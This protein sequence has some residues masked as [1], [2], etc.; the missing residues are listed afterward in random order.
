MRFKTA[1]IAVAAVA[2]SFAAAGSA[3]AQSFA[4]LAKHSSAPQQVSG[5]RLQKGLLPGSAFGS[6]FT[7]NNRLNTGSRLRS[8]HAVLHVSSMKCGAFEGFDYVAGFGN[9]AGALDQYNNPSWSPANPNAVVYGFQDVMQFASTKAATNFYNASLSKYAACHSF[10][11][12]NPGDKSPGGGTLQV[13]NLTLSKIKVNGDHAFFDTQSVALSEFPGS[14]LYLNI[15]IVVAGTNVYNL[16]DQNGTNDE[17]APM[18][19][20]IHQVQA[21]Y[22]HK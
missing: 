20:L 11:E 4:P 13:N 9:T 1:A 6:G 18:G 22:P 19:K 12:P 17:P 15:L 16:F 8:T 14:T 2:L 7:I 21:L 5:S 10:S 3:M